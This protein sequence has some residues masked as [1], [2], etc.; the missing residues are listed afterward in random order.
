VLDRK[1]RVERQQL[2]DIGLA[3]IGA[4][5]M[6]ERGNQVPAACGA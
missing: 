3:F 6:A 2:G 5:E 4:P 1:I